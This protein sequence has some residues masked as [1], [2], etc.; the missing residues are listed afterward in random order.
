M[1]GTARARPFG[2]A[3][4]VA[5]ILAA[6]LCL[7]GCERSG[8]Q[9]PAAAL[10][11]HPETAA[12]SSPIATEES[13]PLDLETPR[14][15][16]LEVGKVHRYNFD[17]KIDEAVALE[18]SQSTA[19]VEVAIVDP[20]GQQIL[21]VDTPVGRAAPEKLCLVARTAG[22]FTLLVAPFDQVGAYRVELLRQRPATA[23]DQACDQAQRLF[24]A[25]DRR[26]LKNG[27]S[28][29]VLADFEQAHGLWRQAGEPFLAALALREAGSAAFGLNRNHQ[30]VELFRQA[31]PLA[32]ETDS[33]YL[34]I[35]LLD[36]LAAVL[37]EQGEIRPSEELLN[38]ALTLARWARDRHLEADIRH[39]LGNVRLFAGEPHRAI[40]LYQQ[41][42]A[43]WQ[44][45]DLISDRTRTLHRLGDA[46]ALLD[47]HQEALGFLNDA[48]QMSRSSPDPATEAGVL[49]SIG[50]L[51]VL[52]DQA[53]QAV[54]VF[55]QALELEREL[56]NRNAEVALLDRLGT[57]LLE[58]GDYAAALDAYNRAFE[59]SEHDGST[60]D[61]ANTAANIGC[62]YQRWGQTAQAALHL[63]AAK[64][65]LQVIDDPLAL[66]HAEYCLAGVAQ[67]RGDLA[68][69]L[70]HIEASLAIVDRLRRTARHRGARHRPIWLWQDYAELQVELLMA[71]SR[72]TGDQRF[73]VRAFEASDLARARNL[74]ELVLESLVGVRSTAAPELLEREHQI[75]TRL[76]SLETRRR[77]LL[78]G[79]A[80]PEEVATLERR[81][82][83][84][85]L[86]LER[87]RA[88]I[89]R[90]DPRYAELA[91]PRSVRLAELQALLDPQTVLLSYAL[92]EKQSTLFVVG[93][94]S[95]ESWSLEPRAH[96]NAQGEALYRALG[97]S[98]SNQIQYQLTAAAMAEKLLP[99]GAIPGSAK[100][101]L[102]VS[103]GMLHYVPFAVL[104]SPR[105]DSEDDEDRLLVDDFEIQYL[106]SASVL[107]ALRRRDA[108]R[109]TAPKT[110]AI[111]ADAIFSVDDAQ[112]TEVT[113][114]EPQ[115]QTRS[116][117]VERLPEGPLPR[118]PFTRDEAL[119]ILA[120]LPEHQRS[121]NLDY[122]A[123]KQA[124]LTKPLDPYRIVHFATHALI[125]ERFP[126]L[127]GLVL[128]RLDAAG[129]EIDGNLH[130]HEIYNLQLAAD[131]VVLSGCQTALGQRVRGDGLLS[132]T[133][134]FLYAGSS[135]VLV[136]LW[137]VDDEATAQLMAQLYHGMIERHESPAAALRAAQRWMRQQPRW[138]APYYWAAFVLQGADS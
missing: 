20:L 81:L 122:A 14:D 25:A 79:T 66:S 62:L 60:R 33:S 54:P 117:S 129:R 95:F 7:A 39:A 90:A 109:P 57:A 51:H 133:R 29:D 96:L 104:P 56:G 125:D 116:V 5:T 76:N 121:A 108:R 112:L 78:T 119:S 61:A 59:L 36:R 58:T 63:E 46:Y 28:A 10:E 98:R 31:L 72:A 34:E 111:F 55:R 101:L 88:E 50:W 126:E 97:Q 3:I 74:F 48:L 138:R 73:A 131:L 64:D 6:A 94:S 91:E 21:L 135:Q 113:D 1:I 93:R 67:Q 132:L 106:P 114:R 124:V 84:T 16:T 103:G 38:Q 52:S 65:R 127:S 19:D 17:L 45:L 75:Q 128:S 11:P 30:A 42:M 15:G 82:G 22:T 86:E 8:P 102:V 80:L 49:L 71:Q 137:S 69:A 40:E 43:I 83:E 26:Q 35:N 24:A 32:R 77:D 13:V 68:A 53:E 23:A 130:L 12:T 18:V 99:P 70:S 41:A 92:G 4:L 118:L 2:V 136:S 115:P 134:G 37:L 27:P 123:T 107:A 47:H 85:S 44:E 9:Q 120:L 110:V 100:R 87:A 89:R 105:R